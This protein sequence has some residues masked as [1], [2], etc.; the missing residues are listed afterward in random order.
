MTNFSDGSV[1]IIIYVEKLFISLFQKE[2]KKSQEK[3]TKPNEIFSDKT[4]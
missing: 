3:R 1:F 4:D 2:A